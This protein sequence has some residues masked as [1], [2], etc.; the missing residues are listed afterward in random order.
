MINKKRVAIVGTGQ[1]GRQL[2]LFLTQN[3]IEIIIKSRSVGGVSEVKKNMEKV[4][5]KLHGIENALKI[6]EKAK[7]TTNFKE[8]SSSPLIFES[9]VEDYS[10]KMSV[11]NEISSI[12]ESSAIIATNTSS[13]S[14]DKLSLSVSNP[15]RFLGVHFFN[16]VHK[17]KL[18]ELVKG[19]ETSDENMKMI[20]DFVIGLEKEPIIVHDTPGFIVNR[21]LLPFINESAIMV[22]RGVAPQDVDKA[23][24]LGL[25]HPMGPL[26]LADLIGID[27]CV[28]ILNTLDAELENGRYTPAEL[29]L[30][31]IERG[32]TGRK[33]G[34]GFYDYSN[35]K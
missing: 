6:L 13:L 28:S 30:K 16:P 27:T 32:E 5:T 22:E 15:D 2:A 3:D 18:V 7:F 17:M 4:L 8:I 12:V 31:M 23:V 29:L 24:K 19:K 20:R 21:L 11:L 1:M 35:K 14:I 26:E 9:V 25:N 34:K 33:V 10:I